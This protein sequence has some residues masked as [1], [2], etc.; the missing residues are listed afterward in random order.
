MNTP[1]RVVAILDEMASAGGPCGVSELSRQLG[2]GKNNVF[3]ILSALED[4][5]WLE[6]DPDTKKYGLTGAMAEVAFRALSQLD[7][8][9]ISLP[10]LHELQAATGET[11]AL[12]IRVELERMFIS[13]VPSNHEVRHF[14]TVGKRMKLWYGSGGKAILANMTD[15]EIDI[16]LRQFQS[17]GASAVSDGHIVNIESLRTELA[18]IRKKGYAVGAGEKTTGVCGVSA[19]I[20][21]H[22]QKVVGCI[23]VS[24]PLPRFDIEKANENSDLIM[25]KAKKI[26]S[27]LGAKVE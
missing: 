5:G 12:T 7:I 4:K 3:R 26:S 24:G 1:E 14:V 22:N 17:S 9:K 21:N 15:E 25:E 10:Y 8:Q 18:E 16:V 20:F 23:S 13:C 6:Q 2:I 19:P 27:I 11:S